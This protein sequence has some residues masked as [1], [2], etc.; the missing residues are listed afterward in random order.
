MKKIILALGAFICTSV[1]ATTIISK[2]MGSSLHTVHDYIHEV[3]PYRTYQDDIIVVNMANGSAEKFAVFHSYNGEFNT[4]VLPVSLS[5]QETTVLSSSIN[6]LNSVIDSQP[7]S[8]WVLPDL[9]NSV[10]EK[11]NAITLANYEYNKRVVENAVADKVLPLIHKALGDLSLISTNQKLEIIMPKFK[12]SDGT[13]VRIEFVYNRHD[14]QIKVVSIVD[15]DNNNI[16][17][18]KAEANNADFIIHNPSAD[19]VQNL[20]SYFKEMGIKFTGSTSHSSNVVIID[21]T[22]GNCKMRQ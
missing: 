11:I 14:T 22:E 6:G 7:P 1:N 5:T 3:S 17:Q 19:Y 2:G 16:P 12:L 9:T 18:T 10:N 15:K 13:T 8:F 4:S 21:C 20:V